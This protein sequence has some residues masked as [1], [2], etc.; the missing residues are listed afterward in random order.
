MAMT[1]GTIFAAR[2][3]AAPNATK[4]ND[5]ERD[6]E[7]QGRS[8]L[9]RVGMRPGYARRAFRE[10]G[11]DSQGGNQGQGGTSL[12]GPATAMGTSET[13]LRGMAQ[14]RRKGKVLTALTSLYL[15]LCQLIAT[16]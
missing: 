1:R 14:N 15:A 8:A 13:R 3:I 4:D 6:P 2:L 12:S 11:G 7:M 5:R 9:F 10:L 16:R